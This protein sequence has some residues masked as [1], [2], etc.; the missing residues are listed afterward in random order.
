MKMILIQKYQSL[1]DQCSLQDGT[2]SIHLAANILND[3]ES[4]DNTLYNRIV[5][6]ASH[7]ENVKKVSLFVDNQE[8]DPVQDV[9][10]EVDNRIKM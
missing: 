1:V 10:G 5:K 7:L 4:I 2:L 8:I 6:S 9:N 3:N